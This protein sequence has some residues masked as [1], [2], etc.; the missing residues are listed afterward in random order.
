[1][2]GYLYP[3]LDKPIEINKKILRMTVYLRLFFFLTILCLSQHIYAADSLAMHVHTV[4]Q[5]IPETEKTQLDQ[6]VDAIQKAQPIQNPKA[7][8]AI[9]HSLLAESYAQI[10]DHK[11]PV[12]EWLFAHALS[13]IQNTNN[14]G[15]LIW[16]NTL[17]GYYYYKYNDYIHALP[18]FLES[19]RRIDSY[20]VRQLPEA[21]Q[22]LI[23][24]A[25]FFGTIDDNQ[26]SLDLLQAALEI[27]PSA[28]TET[29]QILYAIGLLYMKQEKWQE[30]ESYFTRT[31]TSSQAN[32]DQLRYAKTLG[33]LAI[34]YDR[35]GETAKAISAQLENIA[36]SHNN[37]DP[38]NI[39][40]AQI[41]LGRLYLQHRV[42]DS[43]Q[44]YLAESLAYAETK[45]YLKSYEKNIIE[46][47]LDIAQAKGDAARE[48]SLRRRLEQI[49]RH[50]SLT[51]GQS[52]VDQV[53]W[54]TQK[55][56][57]R[58][59]LEAEQN[60]LKRA[61]LLKW[62]WGAVSLLLAL[63]IILLLITHKKRLK[64]QQV[65]FERKLLSFQIEKIESE[66]TLS[67]THNTLSSY[68]VYLK[69]KNEQIQRLEGEITK[70][71]NNGSTSTQKQ[72]FSLESLLKS[73]LLTDEN[74]FE[75]KK[76]FMAENADAYQ[77]I[78]NCLPDITES[79]LRIILLLKMG[80]DNHQISHL[81][82]VTTDA[83][84]KSKQRMRK[85]YG[86][87]LDPVFNFETIED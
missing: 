14:T 84:R 41:Q 8:S 77:T 38:R 11:T 74:W 9:Y 27:T 17:Y 65:E 26:K 68:Q 83:V 85:K 47:Q 71:R 39:M 28:S 70:L 81:L 78:L 5:E 56:R 44:H 73:H 54:E 79:N 15:L 63:I 55:E 53:N 13:D 23:K 37:N 22:V 62:A 75:F 86:E 30:A 7:L 82:G 72:R 50:L 25:Y 42:L 60:K 31:L 52:I 2:F 48:L 51:D 36:I 49:N 24:N 21:N 43:A 35:R 33:E 1:M 10:K 69:D 20:P 66:T 3:D 67:N 6:R 46:L 45:D 19:S 61:S 59:Q 64:L 80:L 29:G 57:I 16:V 76:A 4:L 34:L 58:W 87:R 12:S 32:A 40:Y 18:Y